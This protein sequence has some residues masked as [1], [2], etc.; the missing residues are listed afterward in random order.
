MLLETNCFSHA[1][2]HA[3]LAKELVT[4]LHKKGLTQSSSH[5]HLS[6]QNNAG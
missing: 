3:K 1:F 4:A 6:S 2:Q 5:I